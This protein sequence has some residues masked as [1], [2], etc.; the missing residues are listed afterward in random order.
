MDDVCLIHHDLKKLQE[1]LDVTNHV[2]NK[3][4]IQF[5][6]AKCKVIKIGRGKKSA[7]YWAEKYLKKS[8]PT[9]TWAK[10]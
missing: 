1:I 10:S 8:Q 4:H 5:G 6:A 9:N 7:L 3:Y 2:A